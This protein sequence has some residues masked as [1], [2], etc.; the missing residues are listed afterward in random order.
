MNLPVQDAGYRISVEQGSVVF[1]GAQVIGERIMLD[2]LVKHQAQQTCP[3]P[4]RCAHLVLLLTQQF[5]LVQLWGI[6]MRRAF[7]DSILSLSPTQDCCLP[8]AHALGPLRHASAF[9]S[10][11]GGCTGIWGGSRNYQWVQ[12]HC[13][14]EGNHT[15]HHW[16][17]VGKN[18]E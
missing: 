2:C 1:S 8:L 10:N 15:P 7:Q 11:S 5:K 18:E 16:I 12:R 13:A 4:H 14:L 17:P 9:P 6:S 3:V